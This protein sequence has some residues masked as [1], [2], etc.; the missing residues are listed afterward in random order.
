MLPGALSDEFPDN[1]AVGARDLHAVV[2][3]RRQGRWRKL[4]RPWVCKCASARKVPPGIL[5]KQQRNGAA[6]RPSEQT[7]NKSRP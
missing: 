6:G 1:H 2:F 3:F 7:E 4:T 5:Q